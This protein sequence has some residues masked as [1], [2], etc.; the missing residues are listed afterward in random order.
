VVRQ[1]SGQP[2]AT[3]AMRSRMRFPPRPLGTPQRGE[4]WGG[5]APSFVTSFKRSKS[6]LTFWLLPPG[7][8]VFVR[9]TRI[10]LLLS[11]ATC[12]RVTARGILARRKKIDAAWVLGQSPF[13]IP[14]PFGVLPL[15]LASSAR[16]PLAVQRGVHKFLLL[17]HC[18]PPLASRTKSA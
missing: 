7:G 13:K 5:G 14:P 1:A 15:T 16:L 6:W 11:F 8:G 4:F 17:L 10:P 18:S 9:A 12:R 3:L 2:S